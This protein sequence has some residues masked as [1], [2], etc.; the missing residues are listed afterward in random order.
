MPA[1][2]AHRSRAPHL[3]QPLRR[4][5]QGRPQRKSP[6]LEE[7]RPVRMRRRGDLTL[8][9]RLA[10]GRVRAPL[11]ENSA[12]RGPD[13]RKQNPRAAEPEK[14]GAGEPNRGKQSLRAAVLSFSEN[15]LKGK[16]RVQVKKPPKGHKRGLTGSQKGAKVAHP[17]RDPEDRNNRCKFRPRERS[18]ITRLFGFL[19]RRY[20][21]ADISHQ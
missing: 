16:L 10:A 21:P 5:V 19:P 6:R 1:Q 11:L 20:R 13:Q 2:L 4:R 3:L 7:H 17:L 14:S 15:R 8:R 12:V 18:A 9:Y